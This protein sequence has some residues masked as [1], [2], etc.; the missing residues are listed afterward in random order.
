MKIG[1]L[2]LKPID[3]DIEGVIKAD[4]EAHLKTEVEEYV[5]TNEISKN[6]SDL[7]EQYNK[8]RPTTNGVWISGFFGS[9]KSH[10]LKILSLLLENR[11]WDD[12]SVIQVLHDKI[13]S[14]DAMLRGELKKVLA[15]RSKS[16]LFNIDQKATVVNNDEFDAVVRV[17]AKVFDDFCGYYGNQGYVANFER[18]LDQ[19]GLY[20]KFME[21]YLQG[22]GKSWHEGREVFNIN[23]QKIAHAYAL[24]TGNPEDSSRDIIQSYRDDYK[25]SIEG[26]ANNVNAFIQTQEKGFRLNFFVDEV[27]QYIAENVKLMTN[28][29]TIAESL[30]TICN[31]QAWLFVTSQ[32]DMSKV[33]GE[34]SQK[35]G[36][37][38]SKIQARF[39]TKI[40][41]SSKDVAEV[42]QKRLLQK[43]E[44]GETE[45]QALYAQQN[46]NFGTLFTFPDGSAS[47]KLYRDEAEFVS[48]YP[49]VPYQYFL[50]QQSIETLSDHNAFT[51]K[52]NSVGERSMLGV[53]QDV[54]KTIMEQPAGSLGSFDLMFEGIRSAFKA[55]IQS[56]VYLAEHNLGDAFA[57]KLLKAL[58]LVKYVKGF[59]ATPRNLRVLMQTSFDEN[60][61][62]LETRVRSA[63]ALLEQ[64]TYVQRNEDVYEYLTEEEH[65][66]ENEIKST[67]VENDEIYKSLDDIFFYDILRDSKIRYDANQQ[68]YAFAKRIDGKQRTNKDHELVID[69]I[70][71]YDPF[72]DNLIALKAHSL[73]KAD[74]LVVL[75]QDAQF[76][77]DVL[78][79]IRTD[80]YIKQHH[81]VNNSETK[82]AIFNNKATQNGL[83]KKAISQ[84][85]A[86][87]VGEARFIAS[88]DEVEV[89]GEDAKT[90]IV[91]A[92]NLLIA[93]IYPH[94][95]MLGGVNYTENDIHHY[96]EPQSGAL[97]D[98]DA[99]GMN[100]A[101]LEL[102]TF[103]NNNKF[104]GE[105]TT[106]KALEEKFG[107]RPYGW[108]LAAIQCVVAQLVGRG[109]LE[110]WQEGNL[111]ENGPLE[112]ALKNTYGFSTLNLEPV[113]VSDPRVIQALKNFHQDF[114][115]EPTAENEVRR[116]IRSLQ[117][118]AKLMRDLLKTHFQQKSRYPFLASLAGVIER[119]NTLLNQ[120][121]D[122]FTTVLPGETDSWLTLKEDQIDPLLSFMS[123]QKRAIYDELLDFTN[124][125]KLD[126]SVGELEKLQTILEDPRIFADN[127]LQKAKIVLMQ[128]EVDLRTKLSEERQQALTNV[129][130]LQQQMQHML[131]YLALTSV[132][133]TE[134]DDKFVEVTQILQEQE[135]IISVRA[136]GS[137]FKH[138]QYPNILT[139][140]HRMLVAEPTIN[141]DDGKEP[142]KVVYVHVRDVPVPMGK[143][144][145]ESEADVVEYCEAVKQAL[146]EAICANKRINL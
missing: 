38:F 134:L 62:A 108:Y 22:T 2:F 97:F 112:R 119:L 55:T 16:I 125:K 18:E 122:Y 31:G 74:L 40:H 126:L 4:D 5:V 118:K 145:L 66:V 48:S 41:L 29:Q 136:T 24:T 35:L 28:L 57:V 63:L 30:A 46:K 60:I 113:K 104:K 90:R 43:T 89:S 96:L 83:R 76:M 103:I 133:K 77:Q 123:G 10:L 101:E 127:R 144:I 13:P 135:V 3:R 137:D 146:M 27:G 72:S 94:L 95:Q 32:D 56:S 109:K 9:G 67:N 1:E 65:D 105:R 50:F 106:M 92:F 45:I 78:M 6:L 121:H 21:I 139:R 115:S 19:Q 93:K 34:L 58:F 20:Q 52:H 102:F 23:R 14:T 79:T 138:N 132:Q 64:Q 100:E 129:G 39:Q 54:A 98:A 42:I 59:K 110:T 111:L 88:G 85:A 84:R 120:D 75:P 117:D 87:L 70:S 7:L 86:A 114:F 128:I 131:D 71:P 25:P 99:L 49:F 141:P 53:F 37:D 116:L 47:Y 142:P 140:M 51:G 69:I 80:S 143:G 68:D 61:Q 12:I 36:N 33:F 81:A 73:D 17:F 91:K 130:L 8:L 44:A 82:T 124:Q 26:F 15:T 11:Q 107:S